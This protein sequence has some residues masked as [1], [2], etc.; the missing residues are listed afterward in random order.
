[1]DMAQRPKD[2]TRYTDRHSFSENSGMEGL[3]R[4]ARKRYK[5]NLTKTFAGNA[6]SGLAQDAHV[7]DLFHKIGT[8]YDSYKR[9]E[10]TTIKVKRISI[11]WKWDGVYGDSSTTDGVESTPQTVFD[12][13]LWHY[14]DPLD[15]QVY[16]DDIID[17]QHIP[18]E[19]ALPTVEFIDSFS[20]GFLPRMVHHE[21][22]L[23]TGAQSNTR[24]ASLTYTNTYRIDERNAGVL[25]GLTYDNAGVA[26][27]QN[28]EYEEWSEWESRLP[29]QR[30][31]STPFKSYGQKSY[32]INREYRLVEPNTTAPTAST[33]WNETI[34]IVP[35]SDTPETAHTPLNYQFNWL[36]EYE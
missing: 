33:L 26:G 24:N 16:C 3:F 7:I 6:T 15:T 25:T 29:F 36:V 9:G 21:T 19:N 22:Y 18:E 34:I 10:L 11:A 31:A 28:L 4:E 35:W 13:S 32:E 1:M 12:C 2:R 30:I 23:T 14:T 17:E 27:D 20:N 8:T 5:P